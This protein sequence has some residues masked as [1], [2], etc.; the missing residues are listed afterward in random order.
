[1]QLIIFG[2]SGHAYVVIESALSINSNIIGYLDN[3]KNNLN[4]FHLNYYG[5]DNVIESNKNF[6][7]YNYVLGI[8]D[9]FIR[10]KIYNRFS[11][12]ISFS[13]IADFSS[14][15]SKTATLGNANYFGKNCSINALSKIGNGTIIN[16][17]AIIE[18]ECVI[19][20]FV[21]IA[22]NAVLCGNVTIGKN[23]FIGA[24]SVVRQGVAIGENVV[25]G[26]GSVV[27]KNIPNNKKVYGNPAK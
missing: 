11:S 13:T 22:P 18:H 6:E 25:V 16:T 9:N 19:D 24:N 8:G 23:S 21:H 20:D 12:L 10:E 3:S 7:N 27:V 2:Y 15:I 17:N 5:N 26:A 14:N 4:P 1:M